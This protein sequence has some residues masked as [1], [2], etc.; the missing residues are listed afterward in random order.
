M[1]GDSSAHVRAGPPEPVAPARDAARET[2]DE[3]RLQLPRTLDSR[4]APEQLAALVE[5]HRAVAG[6]LDR[7]SLFA[8][9]AQALQAVV[10]V[11][12]SLLLLPSHDPAVLT[13]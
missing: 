12:R 11:S 7:R 1:L 6:H 10:P 13:I 8:G 2:A 3:L 9:I 5:I 4:L